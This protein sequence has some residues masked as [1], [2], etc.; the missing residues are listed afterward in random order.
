MKE[1]TKIQKTLLYV[2]DEGEVSQQFGQLRKQWQI[3]LVLTV[4]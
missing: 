4:L 2:G 1:K 3:C